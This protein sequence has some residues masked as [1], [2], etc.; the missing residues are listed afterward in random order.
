MADKLAAALHGSELNRRRELNAMTKAELVDYILGIDAKMRT[1]SAR[2]N[3]AYGL[4][5]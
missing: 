1:L 3:A 5:P 2:I 4:E